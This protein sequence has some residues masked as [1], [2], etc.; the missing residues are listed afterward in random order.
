MT[1]HGNGNPSTHFGRQIKKERLARG[2]SLRQ[3]SAHSGVD[4]SHLSKIEAGKRPPT[5]KVAD[6][7]DAVFL[8]RKG[9]FREYYEDSK[10]SIPPGLRSWAEHE[11]KAVR[12]SIWSPGIV[13][14]LFQTPDYARVFLST[15]NAPAEV[16]EARLAN[17]MARQQRVLG[18]DDPPT[19]AYIIDHVALYRG[20]GS[21]ETM[22]AQMRHVRHE[23]HCY[24]ARLTGRD[25]R[26]YLWI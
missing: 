13:H 18:R 12:L 10:S 1:V 26:S 16:V 2:W 15:L 17:R 21:A 5:A 23:A 25:E 7:M 6:A 19:V 4:F 3:L 20:V 24:I 22:A 14:G 11:D 8:D 9:W